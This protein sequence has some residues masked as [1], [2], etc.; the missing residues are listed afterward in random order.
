M[1]ISRQKMGAPI[2]KGSYLTCEHCQGRGVVKSVETQALY[3]LRRIQTGILRKK[4][5]RVEC[6]LPLEVANYLLN[7]KRKELTDLEARHQATIDVI[8]RPEMKPGENRIDFLQAQ[9]G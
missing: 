5:H 8:P 2:E 9:A 3:F 1:Q 4:V 7:K 6:R